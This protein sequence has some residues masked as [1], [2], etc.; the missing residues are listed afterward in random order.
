MSTV[1]PA[2]FLIRRG[3]AA[4]LASVNEI[5]LLG[6]F[7]YETD[8]GL[9]SGKYQIKIG[10]GSRHYNDLP[11]IALGADQVKQIMPVVTGSVPPVLVYLDDG[12]LV[13]S[14]IN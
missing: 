12:S 8:Q 4:D 1:V 10:D 9:S 7:V 5:P 14:E 13:Y 11:Y 6:E 2:R 3:T